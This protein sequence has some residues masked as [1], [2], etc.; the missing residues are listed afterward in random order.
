LEQALVG[1]P[2]AD[3]S[4][5]LEVLRVIH[6]FDP[7]LACAVHVIDTEADQVYSVKVV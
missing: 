5:P 2:V 4:N 3:P 7:C 1:V 6:S